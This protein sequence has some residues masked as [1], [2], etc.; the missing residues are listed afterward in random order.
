M[1]AGLFTATWR[2]PR[3][4]MSGPRL[5]LIVSEVQELRRELEATEN[6][7]SIFCANVQQFWTSKWQHGLMR[8]LSIAFAMAT[9][10]D[11]AVGGAEQV[12]AHI[13]RELIAAG[14][15]SMVV[16]GCYSQVCGT[17]FATPPAPDRITKDYYSF[18]Y[19]EHSRKVKEA[20]NNGPIDLVHMHGFDFYEFIPPGNVPVLATL[21]LPPKWYVNWIYYLERTNFYLSCVSDSQRKDL[22]DSRLVVQ[23]VGNGV[24]IPPLAPLPLAERQGAVILGR[25]CPEKGTHIGIEAAQR[26][27]IHLTIAGRVFGY[28]EHLDYFEHQIQPS[29]TEGVTYL[30]PVGSQEKIALLRSAKCVLLPSTAPETSSLVAMEAVACGTP[31]IAMRTGALPEIVEHGR[32]GFL[33]NSIEEMAEAIGH[34]DEIDPMTCRRAAETRFSAQR[35]AHEYIELYER[36]IG[37]NPSV[38]LPA[39]ASVAPSSDQR[40]T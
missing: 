25:I 29:L 12:L 3:R 33:V 4:G 39:G 8:I 19:V 11:D 14:H 32:T 40:T 10:G 23:T 13:D 31:V 24:G 2:F 6:N 7:C 30:G 35:M 36:L 28:P 20:L 16:A 9:V 5:Q 15:E 1:S 21:H 26:A 37:V 17:L 34:A 38:L 22:P 27:R 18:R